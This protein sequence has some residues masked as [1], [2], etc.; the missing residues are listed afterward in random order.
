MYSGWSEY[1]RHSAEWVRKTDAFLDHAFQIMPNANQLGVKCPCAKCSNRIMQK[2]PLIRS[3]LSEW[4]FMLGY[5]RWTEHGEPPAVSST[6]TEEPLHSRTEVSRLSFVQ[7]LMEL[8][9]K[10]NFT[11]EGVNDILDLMCEVCP[12]GH[13]VPANVRECKNLL[14]GLETR[15]KTDKP[16]G[17]TSKKTEGES[18]K[19][20]RGRIPRK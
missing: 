13:K 9:S 6:R 18:S 20:K 11:D 15:S 2:Q 14:S 1:G 12:E 5:T 17:E 16:E 8:K 7:G 19:K 10:F 4:G 3:H